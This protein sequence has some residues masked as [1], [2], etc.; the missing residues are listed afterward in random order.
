MKGKELIQFLGYTIDHPEFIAFL[1][2]HEIDT[3]LLQAP[4][5]LQK[6]GSNFSTQVFKQGFTLNFEKDK[7][8][9]T[10]ENGSIY[11]NNIA[12]F[13][14]ES[15]N[16]IAFPPILLPFGLQFNDNSLTLIEKFG[17]KKV[18]GTINSPYYEADESDYVYDS[19]LRS[20]HIT[21]YFNR[22]DL[23]EKLQE[24]L[25]TLK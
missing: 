5:I 4:N 8:N 12:F 22:G 25:V 15:A 23:Q 19:Y 6:K 3:K 14:P 21:V 20:Y 24:L 13:K 7:L 11:L 17:D 1:E 9:K 16:A 10:A 18:H 2:A